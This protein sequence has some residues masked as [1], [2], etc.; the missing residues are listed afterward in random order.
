MR[1]RRLN[2]PTMMSYKKRDLKETQKAL[3]TMKIE[4]CVKSK[5]N[6]F[7]KSKLNQNGLRNQ[8]IEFYLLLWLFVKAG[9]RGL[10][11]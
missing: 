6:H 5:L 7:G 1:K 9:T 4:Q 10:K 2:R 8:K 3:L 11:L